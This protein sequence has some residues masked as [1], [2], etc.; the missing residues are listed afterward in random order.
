M[1]R[2]LLIEVSATF[3][4][5]VRKILAPNHYDIDIAPKFDKGITRL[6]DFANNSIT[7]DAVILGWPPRCHHDLD[8]LLALLSEPPW[9]A[10]PLLILS[11]QADPEKLNFIAGRR[12]SALVLWSDIGDC[13]EA[14]TGLIC[15]T[16]NKPKTTPISQT[17][18]ILFVDDSPTVRASFRRLLSD[19]GYHVETAACVQEGMQKALASIFDIAIIDYFMPDQTGDCLVDQL[20]QEPK[21]EHVIS[22]VIT[23][24]YSDK[25]ISECLQAGAVECLFKNEAKEL[26]LARVKSLSRSVLSL[27]RIEQESKRL[28]GILSSVGDG[29]Y[30]VNN[31]GDI[32]FL[33]PAAREMLGIKPNQKVL[34]QSAHSLFHY[35]F[36]DGRPIPIEA[37][38]LSGSYYKGSQ[39]RGWQTV[40]WHQDGHCV[41]VECTIFP[42]KIDD[43][44]EGSVIAFRDISSQK[45]LEQELRWQATHDPLTKLLNRTYFESQLEHEAYRLQKEGRYSALLFIDL[46]HFKQVNDNAGHHAGDYLLVE[47]GQRLLSQ[48]R[49]TDTLA[50]IGGNE[51]AIIIR[52]VEL[53]NL[54][55]L[56]DVYRKALAD[57]QFH[58]AGRNYKITATIGV[59]VLS[60]DR[61][62][63]GEA[64]SNADIACHIAKNKGR[65]RIHIFSALPDNHPSAALLSN[66]LANALNEDLFVLCFQPI[67]DMQDV[68]AN[69]RKQGC[70]F[71]DYLEKNG[72]YPSQYE[73]L[74][75]LKDAYG[76]MVSADTFIPTAKRFNM[77]FEI[78][79]WVIDHAIKTLGRRSKQQKVLSISINLSAQ[80][81]SER[82]IV[83]Y[84]TEKIQQYRVDPAC[85]TFE[86]DES[87]AVAKLDSTK[88]MIEELRSMG[89]QF[90]LDNFGGGF[91][92]FGHLKYLDVDIIKIDGLFI[93]GMRSDPI[94]RAVINAINEIAHSLGKRTIAEYVDD[95]EVLDQLARIGVDFAQGHFLG[96]PK[97]DV[98]Y[99]P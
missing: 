35:A 25:V 97:F 79:K 75:R 50:R 49:T 31:E 64:I 96:D 99:I 2:V 83:P 36:E 8:E 46:D 80:T 10:L 6:K 5:A 89:C 82:E 23:G 56:A 52:E 86:I 47:V 32:Q 17:I 20:R 24:T 92:S 62:N 84:V 81:V 76:N 15:G 39:I 22:A 54:V 7:F 77:M 28:E 63:A 33:N 30:G 74:L 43:Q 44:R 51:F 21:T 18:R 87:F 34:G 70:N 65:N 69:W 55:A 4:H 29:V 42:L 78:D 93:R 9:A 71:S 90:A 38:F 53:D 91:C 13:N 57:Q 26:F 14:L 45:L 19:N 66:H 88:W 27:K 95:A 40:F 85:I 61:C 12:L 16:Q 98:T 3:R 67:I 48:L 58:Y 60:K 1:L 59:S 73:V 94:V 37:C 11:E 68:P 41:Q 72:F